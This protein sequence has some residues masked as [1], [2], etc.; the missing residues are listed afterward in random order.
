MSRPSSSRRSAPARPRGPRLRRS[1]AAAGI[2][3]LGSAASAEGPSP[4][5]PAPAA[6]T[7]GGEFSSA[8]VGRVTEL[9]AA[10]ARLGAL[11]ERALKFTPTPDVLVVA[12]QLHEDH[13]RL[14]GDLDRLVPARVPAATQPRPPL[15]GRVS[16]EFD[17][18]F[19]AE[20]AGASEAA[21]A[22][23]EEIVRS[24]DA[25]ALRALATDAV[26]S[27]DRNLHRIR[28]MQKPPRTDA[29]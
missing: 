18:A 4:A 6:Q 11:A 14:A 26:V 22:L 1:L 17:R 23:C 7:E 2:L 10:N 24:A 8:D 28:A 29:N 5:P 15:E 19:L 25:P 9:R 12:H 21:L 27:L 16:E 13:V 20:A 3:A